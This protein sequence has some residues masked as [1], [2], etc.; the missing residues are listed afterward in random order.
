ML[1]G[2]QLGVRRDRHQVAQALAEQARLEVGAAGIEQVRQGPPV[3]IAGLAAR[4]QG[5]TP[6][7]GRYQRLQSLLRGFG[8][9]LGGATVV[10]QLR[11]VDTDQPHAAAIAQAHGI[12]AAPAK[13]ETTDMKK[14]PTRD[15]FLGT[16]TS[17][18]AR[19]RG[20]RLTWWRR[21]RRNA[22]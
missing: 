16:A 17:S 5:E 3:V 8:E 22:A 13:A 21:I 2:R 9:G 11:R 20:K 19:V 1:T 4:L 18:I 14:A 10:R 12:A 7:A 6:V 15:A